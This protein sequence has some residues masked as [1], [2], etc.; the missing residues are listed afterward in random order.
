MSWQRRTASAPQPEFLSS[1]AT[2]DWEKPR[3]LFVA[4]LQLERDQSRDEDDGV[5]LAHEGF[6]VAQRPGDRVDGRKIAISRRGQSDEAEVN[7][8]RLERGRHG[9]D[10]RLKASG[11]CKRTSEYA[12]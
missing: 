1:P 9:R 8:F 2:K 11:S 6:E 3:L 10:G 5:E 4:K 7:Q 12:E